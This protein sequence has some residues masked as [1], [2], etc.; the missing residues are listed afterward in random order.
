VG[1]H[2]YRFGLKRSN[3]QGEVHVTA[4]AAIYSNKEALI[5]P[6]K[7]KDLSS[8]AN[9]LVGS[10]PSVQVMKQFKVTWENHN[11]TI[12]VMNPNLVPD[13]VAGFLGWLTAVWEAHG[14]FEDEG[15]R[16]WAKL[17]DWVALTRQVL[18]ITMEPGT[19]VEGR[20]KSL[21]RN[22]A[23]FYDGII[24]ADDAIYLSTGKLIIGP[25]NAQ[26]YV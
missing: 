13:H 1:E 19:D 5:E 11:V 25:D 9:V 16:A 23:T 15:E 18:G 26:D 4:W 10:V 12:N 3:S 14:P 6:E 7:L 22:I 8:N 24:F 21:V 17:L 2:N 20:C